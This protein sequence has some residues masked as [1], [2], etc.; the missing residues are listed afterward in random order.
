VR[1]RNVQ[2]G[3]KRDVVPLDWRIRGQ[4]VVVKYIRQRQLPAQPLV[5]L[6]DQAEV[7]CPA[8]D[9]HIIGRGAGERDIYLT[10]AWI[11]EE[12]LREDAVRSELVGEIIAHGQCG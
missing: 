12:A 10:E 8:Q 3:R 5:E 7:D 9:P 11:E 1:E 4:R 6:G 2:A